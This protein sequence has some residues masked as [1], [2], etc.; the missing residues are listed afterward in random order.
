MRDPGGVEE[1]ACG[2]SLG[3]IKGE[4][5]SVSQTQRMQ[6][7]GYSTYKMLGK[8]MPSVGDAA[9]SR[10]CCPCPNGDL[11]STERR[12]LIKESYK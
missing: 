8:K 6:A 3:L 12:T 4:R 5:T 9:A 2:A 11:Q 7:R 10:M 1:I